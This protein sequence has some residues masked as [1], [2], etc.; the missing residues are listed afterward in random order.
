MEVTSWLI[1]EEK[2]ATESL[3][4][5]GGV[6]EVGTLVGL[7]WSRGAR[8]GYAGNLGS[9]ISLHTLSPS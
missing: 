1:E 8:H 9:H 2:Q 7:I 4:R 5:P 6:F 3:A